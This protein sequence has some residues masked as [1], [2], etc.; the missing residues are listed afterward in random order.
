MA[1]LA[2]RF[3]FRPFSNKQKKI[4]N[5]WISGTPVHDYDGIIADGAIRSGKTVS[6]ALAFVIWSMECYDGQNFGMAGKTIG[7]FR[8]N[9]LSPLKNMLPGRGYYLQEHRQ[10]NMVEIRHGR[11]VNYYYIFG[12]KDEAS[13][14][15][16]QG[17]TL[18]GFFFDEV[19]LMPQSFV[20]QATA[21]CSVEGS[22]W[23]FNCNPD[24]PQHW[25]KKEWIDE[26]EEK[27]LVYLHFNMD[28]NLSLSERMKERYR[29]Q[30]SGVF[31][32]RYILGQWVAAD[33]AIYEQFADDPGKYIVDDIDPAKIQFITI[34]VDFGG[35]RSLTTFVATAVE[36]GYR[37]ITAIADYHIKGTKGTI[38]ANRVNSEFISFV[39][40]LQAEYPNVNIRYCFADSEAQYLINGMRKTCKEAGLAVSINDSAKNEITQRIIAGNTLF[41]IG[42]LKIKKGCDILI[43]G[44]Q[45]AVWDSKAAEKGK[46]VRLDNFSSDIDILDAWEYSWER[47]MNK[48]LPVEMVKREDRMEDSYEYERDY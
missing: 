11:H 12:G 32:K 6:M 26:T 46:D 20:N 9:V 7:S 21:R 42:R 38:D 27:R 44:L 28:D 23:W 8:R 22:K 4:L 43:G 30:Y 10:E 15:L 13:Q 41:N 16:V 3:Q 19:A 45:S 17:I 2:G 24:H 39:Q 18:A 25:F 14:D 47:F 36:I 29:R 48:L 5:W 35:N 34:G 40:R 31:Y 1:R 37:S 33:G